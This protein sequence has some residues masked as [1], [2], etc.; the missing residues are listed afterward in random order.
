METL[1]FGIGVYLLVLVLIVTTSCGNF[2][3]RNG[4]GWTD[5][6]GESDDDEC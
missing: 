1:A 5:L 2:R 4:E 6:E 3:R